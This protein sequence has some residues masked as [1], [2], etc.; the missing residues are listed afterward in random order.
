MSYRNLVRKGQEGFTLVEV[1]VVAV[2]VAILA[3][4]SIPLYLGYI[5][6]TRENA[7][8]NA[9]GSAASFMAAC[10]NQGGTP[11]L[12]AMP[13]DGVKAITC[14]ITPTAT[15]IVPDGITLTVVGGNTIKGQHSAGGNISQPYTFKTAVA[16]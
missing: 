14:D 8:A 1:I 15:L 12:P 7:A 9:A 16:P 13:G 3:G 11:T 4:V 6:G 2:I 5:N 10:I